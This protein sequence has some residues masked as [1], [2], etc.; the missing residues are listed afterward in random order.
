MRT[1]LDVADDVLLSAKELATRQKRSTGAVISEL[2]RVGLKAMQSSPRSGK[3]VLGFR[4]LPRR[5]GVVTNEI[6]DR[7]RE[8]DAY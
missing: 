5:G 3:S 8:Q 2:A 1:T 7:L 6:I 4:A